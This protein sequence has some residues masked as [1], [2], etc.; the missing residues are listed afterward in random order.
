MSSEDGA[1]HSGAWG[2]EPRQ[3][4]SQLDGQVEP[5]KENNIEVVPPEKALVSLDFVRTSEGFL[6]VK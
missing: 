2:R 6:L 5:Y 3:Q 4:L 1:S